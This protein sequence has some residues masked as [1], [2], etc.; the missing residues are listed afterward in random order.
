MNSGATSI[1]DASP[2]TMLLFSGF[3][4]DEL[5]LALG[6]V[7]APPL[8]DGELPHA[9]MSSATT[10]MTTGRAARIT[11]V[12]IVVLLRAR[13]LIRQQTIHILVIYSGPERWYIPIIPLA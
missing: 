5:E 11:S 6:D 12:I 8:L 7:L 2:T 4:L 9:T 13:Y 1:T 10:P 3:P